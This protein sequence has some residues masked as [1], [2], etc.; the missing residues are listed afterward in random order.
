M[1]TKNKIE[2]VAENLDFSVDFIDGDTKGVSFSTYSPCGQDFYMEF[3]Y[4]NLQEL[5]SKLYDYYQSYDPSYEASLWLDEWGHG[6]N[7]APYDLG[8]LY[9]DMKWCEA[10]IKEL[11]EALQRAA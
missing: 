9:D 7:G 3:D 11:S 10:Q 1:L 2:K 8:D 5:P 6:K 4:D